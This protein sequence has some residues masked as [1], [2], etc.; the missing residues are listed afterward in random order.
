MSDRHFVRGL[1][2]SGIPLVELNFA[3]MYSSPYALNKLWEK[4]SQDGQVGLKLQVLCTSM[5]DLPTDPALTSH[6]IG[7]YIRSEKFKRAK[8]MVLDDI[9]ALLQVQGHE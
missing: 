1:I 6:C 5:N 9:E 7:K 3:F 4:Y 2:E 8:H